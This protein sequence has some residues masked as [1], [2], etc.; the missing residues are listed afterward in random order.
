LNGL[1]DARR[2]NRANVTI[3]PG[4]KDTDALR[5][6]RKARL[7]FERDREFDAVYVVCDCAGEDL[8]QAAE[9]AARP[10]RNNSGDRIEVQLIV[11]RPSF[12]FWLLLHFEYSARSF[13]DAAQVIDVLRRHVTDY[14]K[15]DRQIFA[16]VATGLD[17]ALARSAQLR[18]DLRRTD[19]ESP[20][21]DMA[22]LVEALDNLRRQI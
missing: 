20:N 5:L 9:L 2:I 22:R 16:K 1:C 19:A 18:A 13:R 15:A 7:R 8:T 4:E 11:S 12:E 3:V 14:E 21:T 10:M 17:L 6:V